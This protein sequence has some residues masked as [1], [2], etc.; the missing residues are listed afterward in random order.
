MYQ[1]DKHKY[2]VIFAF[3]DF[4]FSAING[5]PRRVMEYHQ[6]NINF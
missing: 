2:D 4:E 5:I 6:T 3:E 1:T